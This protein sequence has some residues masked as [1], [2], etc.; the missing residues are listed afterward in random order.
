MDRR[1]VFKHRQE[2]ERLA[3]HVLLTESEQECVEALT[4]RSQVE[5]RGQEEE[6]LNGQFQDQ[7]VWKDTI[8]SSHIYKATLCKVVPG[9]M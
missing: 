3:P 2:F 8:S 1:R 6:W 5:G 7:D 9:E 4:E